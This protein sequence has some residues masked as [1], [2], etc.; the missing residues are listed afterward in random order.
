MDL[1]ILLFRKLHPDAQLPSRGSDEAVGLDIHA[2]EALSI[3]P[4][5]R[6]AIRTGL[7]VMIP[8][9]FYGRIAP[10]S[11]LAVSQGVDVMAGVIDPDYRGEIKCL[12]V[13]LGD[14]VCNISSGDRIAQLIIEKVK[15]LEPMWALGLSETERNLSGFG[16]TG[17]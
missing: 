9:G 15:I 13:N 2:V 3:R 8:L 10:R 11:G 4:G 1:D 12:L 5:E 7:A 6:I 14:Q 16:S 17:V